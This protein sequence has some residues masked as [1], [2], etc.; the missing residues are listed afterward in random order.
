MS[1]RVSWRQANRWAQQDAVAGRTR[2]RGSI[3]TRSTPLQ[4]AK[5]LGN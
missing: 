2:G 3:P 4:Q 1:N 5:I